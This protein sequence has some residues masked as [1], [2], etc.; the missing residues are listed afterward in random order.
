MNPA[1]ESVFNDAESR[2]L[3]AEELNIVGSYVQSI[4]SRLEVYR[5][6]RDQEVNIVQ[7]V[8]DQVQKQFP[9]SALKRIER[10]TKN[11]ILSLRA[12]AT[13]ML[14]NDEGY[15][16]E[17]VQWV[18]QTQINN[19]LAEIDRVF[20]DLLEKQLQQTL[21]TAKMAIVQ[22]AFNQIRAELVSAGGQAPSSAPSP[23]A[24][25]PVA[26]AA[27]EDELNLESLF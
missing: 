9:E 13:G 23:V 15:I 3:S 2:Y 22:P 25:A 4:P 27:I 26:T 10:S 11:A 7:A 1:L 19:D 14:L 18:K 5:F 20:Y 17:R 12:C 6:L 8:V 21:G 24:A 16:R